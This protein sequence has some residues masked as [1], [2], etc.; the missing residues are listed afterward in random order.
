MITEEDEGADGNGGHRGSGIL[1]EG[2]LWKE[3]QTLMED[4]T[5]KKRVSSLTLMM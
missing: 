1:M 5:E 4:V 3:K 2:S